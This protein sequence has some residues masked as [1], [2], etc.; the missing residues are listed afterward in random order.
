MSA[1]SANWFVRR[2]IAQALLW[3]LLCAV[4][5]IGVTVQKHV[6]R[7]LPVA[8]TLRGQTGPISVRGPAGWSVRQTGNA[9]IFAEPVA[10]GSRVLEVRHETTVMFRSPLQ[11]LF[12]GAVTLQD[13]AAGGWDVHFSGLEIGGWPAVYAVRRQS[14]ADAVIA[15]GQ[16]GEVLAA[17]V[18]GPSHALIISLTGNDPHRT[19]GPDLVREIAR[20]IECDVAPVRCLPGESR[21]F[22]C[23][24]ELRCADKRWRIAPA[25]DRL[26]V[27]CLVM[28]GG[29]PGW[30]AV[31]LVPCIVPGATAR[32]FLIEAFAVRNPTL[33][34][35]AVEAWDAHTWRAVA[36]AGMSCTVAFLRA[37][38]DGR[39]I[40]AEFRCDSGA[41]SRRAV[42]QWCDDVWRRI[43][44]SVAFA[45]GF[46]IRQALEDGAEACRTLAPVIV[47]HLAKEPAES[48]W[49][50]YHETLP[51]EAVMR[52]A[53]RVSGDCVEGV[54]R[55]DEPP[56]RSRVG[57]IR[58]WR[59]SR[60][61]AGYHCEARSAYDGAARA[62]AFNARAEQG[63]WNLS[64]VSG[65]QSAGASGGQPRE[66]FV[67]GA[68]LPVFLGRAPYRRM[69]LS[70][71]SLP[72][73]ATGIM[74][75]PFTILVE[76]AFDLP[77][78][79]PP[80]VEPMRCWAVM[81]CG[82]GWSSRWYYDKDGRLAAIAGPAGRRMQRIADLSPTTLPVP[83]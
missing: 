4:F 32:Q 64:D 21:R 9:A 50:L 66:N 35:P 56:E 83:E 49:Q 79:A 43:A 42:A 45:E 70:T 72:E 73:P 58:R 57:V 31:E 39:A 18:M 76:P 60:D 12:G 5:A 54:D 19:S 2:T 52:S 14:A 77:R 41:Q 3:A 17:A 81:P 37:S 75:G 40:L 68:L 20:R 38:D 36:A 22:G 16:G 82:T 30:A 8:G 63:R 24:I 67:P 23:D 78:Y 80:D 15:G 61:G 65:E 25:D 51:R 62:C 53:V 71:E 34:R 33:P 1:A 55:W 74:A 7:G 13:V 26:T 10:R 27:S 6:E 29:A 69:V 44:A 59:I 48:A 47:E 28:P 11:R 46:S